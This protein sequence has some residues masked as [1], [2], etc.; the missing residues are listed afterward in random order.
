[1]EITDFLPKYPNI[2]QTE[3]EILNPYN[4]DFYESI[5]RKKEFYDNR[6]DRNEIF[7]K[8]TGT[9]MKHQKTIANYFSSHTPYD[10]LLLV[11]FMGSGKTCSA[12][13]AIEQIKNEENTFN[14]ALIFA[15]GD[16]ILDNF[17]NELVEKCTA[18]Q[19]LPEGYYKPNTLTHLEKIHRVKKKIKFYKL[20][21]FAKFAKQIKEL[22][23]DEIVNNY[24]NKIIVMD[25]VHNIRI[26]TKTEKEEDVIET[27]KQFHRF[28]HIVQNCKVLFL[29]GT[30]MKD[31]PAEIASIANLLLP[32][33]QQFPT[34]DEFLEEYMDKKENV[35]IM[36][37][38]KI[39]EF[40]QKLKGRVSFLRETE[41]TV[42]KKFLGQSNFDTLKH[43]V[44]FP[45]QMS[46][47]QSY[48]YNEAWNL[49]KSGNQG[50]YI[51]SRQASLFVYPDGSFGKKGFLTYIRET[52]SGFTMSEDLKNALQGE[53]EEETLQRISLCSSNYGQVIRNILNTN[54]NCFV[55]SSLAE[56]SGAILFS[57]LLTL[58]GFKKANGN[59]T[60]KGLRYCL[61]TGELSSAP[62]IR[63]II[64]KFN[65]KNNMHGEYIKVI[66]GTKSVSEGFSFK[67]VIFEAINTPHWNYSETAQALARGIRLGSHNDL[68]Q[69]GE[70]PVVTII[71][72]VAI[73]NLN[74]VESVDMIA[75]KT[76]E[77]K[78]ISIRRILR[79]LMELAFDC[80]LNYFRN[81]VVNGKNFSRECDYTICN[82]KCDGINMQAVK[83]GLDDSELDYSTYKLY[84]ANPKIPQV[85][86]KIEALFRQN[87][88]IDLES[89]IKNLKGEF[90]EEEI[91]NAL[92][93]LN[94]ESEN[95]N[96]FDYKT[97]LRIYSKSDVK[98]IINKIEELFREYFRLDLNVIIEQVG[99]KEF[100]V[101][102]ALNIII[103]DNLILL[104]K[105]GFPCYLREERNTFFLVNNLAV[106]SDFYIEYYSKFPQ[107]VSSKTF[108]NILEDVFSTS[109]PELIQKLCQEEDEKEFIKI[110]KTLPN[111]VQ[112]LFIE[113]SLIAHNKNI[114]SFVKDT[115]LNYFQGYIKKV[116]NTWISTFPNNYRCMEEMKYWRDCDNNDK[117]R[118]QEQE[119][120]IQEQLKTQ[121]P[122][123][124]VGKYNPQTNAFCIVDFDKE[125]KGK[126]RK[127]TDRRLNY[128]GKV[129]DAGGWTTAEL[130]NLAVNRLQIDP[131]DN[132]RNDYTKED[133][134]YEI[135][136]NPKITTEEDL[137][138]MSIDSLRRILYWN[139]SKSEGGNKGIQ[140]ICA[141]IKNWLAENN[142][143]FPDPQCGVQGKKKIIET[144]EEKNPL[145]IE[146]YIPIQNPEFFQTYKKHIAKLMGECFG[147]KK[148]QTPIDNNTWIF[149]FLKKRIVGMIMVD[150]NNT[151]WNVCVG[152][153]FRE[154]SIGK[155]AINEA[156]KLVCSER[157]QTPNL[158]VQN[159]NS[160][161][162]KLIE[163]YEKLGFT[164]SERTDEYT[165]MTYDCS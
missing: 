148:Y 156:I 163:I 122:Y 74:T 123:K 113:A 81:N 144:K 24:S 89:I 90:T 3:Y 115:V 78:D 104:N 135:E 152:K 101:I 71:Q 36:K 30:P 82:Y 155:K 98:H 146:R 128:S 142:L 21:T 56:G 51:N 85:R 126:K 97:F 121:N 87:I 129:C 19:Y 9:L 84:Y 92:F 117:L 23:D 45:T 149:V 88:K 133:L 127:D 116:D 60:T 61:F 145:R 40:K 18:G 58:F 103:N 64:S 111:D 62:E 143:M 46:D 15:K 110:L 151:L 10:R 67:N 27:Y 73:P 107:I 68:I 20:F 7:P 118:L 154:Q 8:E 59:E 47:F 80:A 57:L 140:P 77:D 16:T 158:L 38:E 139:L 50:V 114:E 32:L 96:Q 22:R 164:I 134:I 66:I 147:D 52:K 39:P 25:E 48:Y 106:Q 95:K 99:Y 29:S 159:S 119:E 94:E 44:V 31:S 63:K 2:N 136:N 105:Y 42:E 132:F 161:A 4:E 125:N 86:K 35:Y 83:Q 124:I 109:L 5:F 75:Y 53:D 33:H 141:A 93:T 70:T 131:P 65:S 13:G 17:T 49:D 138:N 157:K 100:E 165:F 150:S 102:T 1:M 137:E 91:K 43:L 55:Y 130:I 120:Q 41:S 26:K 54:G 160:N 37:E 162:Q 28:L 112:E 69:N 34:E 72:P 79:L 108:Q 76:S 153:D 12:I 14:G 6:L 11:H